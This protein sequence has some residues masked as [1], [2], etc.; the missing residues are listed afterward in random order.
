[1]ASGCWSLIGYDNSTRA[2]CE[3]PWIQGFPVMTLID[4]GPAVWIWRSAD[5]EEALEVAGEMGLPV[6]CRRD[7]A[8]EL[9]FE[10]AAVHVDEDPEG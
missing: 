2:C 6:S 10:E 8:A 3:R 4:G 5:F 7:I 9:G 1:M